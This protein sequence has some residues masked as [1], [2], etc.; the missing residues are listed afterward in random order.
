[1]NGD[2]DT[3]AVIALK[4]G[5]L[6]VSRMTRTVTPAELSGEYVV[7]SVRRIGP[8]ALR[9]TITNTESPEPARF[10]ASIQVSPAPTAVTAPVVSTTATDGARELNFRV[11]SVAG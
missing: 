4:L 11:G 2:I 1:M 3:T 6:R 10:V 8:V 7:R 9:G 5:P